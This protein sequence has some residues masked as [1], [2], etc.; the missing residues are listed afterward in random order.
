MPFHMHHHHHHD[1]GAD[2]APPSVEQGSPHAEDTGLSLPVPPADEL[3]LVDP[4]AFSF[5]T[6]R[7]RLEVKP[8]NEDTWYEATIVRLFPL[9]ETIHWLCL[10]DK[11]DK[12]IGVFKELKGLTKEDM[13][14]IRRELR[15]R[16]VIPEIS[17]VV[18][19]RIRH[20]L[21]EWDVDT[22]RGRVTFLTKQRDE[23]QQPAVPNRLSI[24]DI[25]G[26]RFDIPDVGS[27]D[28]TSRRALAAW[29]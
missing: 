5:R 11:R 9:T 23:Q 24:T 18:S 1:H 29:F 6:E 20:D 7:G 12:E 21:V 10:L 4:T 28:V 13:E 16:Y 27:L 14:S 17:R 19:C 25:E 22:D 2:Q 26:N 3:H 15:R 8:Q